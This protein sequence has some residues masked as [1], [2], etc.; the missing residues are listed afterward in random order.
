VRDYQRTLSATMDPM[1]ELAHCL[2]TWRDRMTPEAVGLTNGGRRRAPGLRREE[3]AD[4]A[5][6]SVDY[7]CG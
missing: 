6:V 2:R 1:D 3:L 4:L 5:G 7:R